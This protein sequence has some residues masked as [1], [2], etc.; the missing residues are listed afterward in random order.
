MTR[1]F[2][3][4]SGQ[5]PKGI[6]LNALRNMAHNESPATAAAIAYFT[7]FSIFPLLLLI[8]AIC[9]QYF[10]LF[11]V[12]SVAIRAVLQFF[13]G[14]RTF[15]Q[16]NIASVKPSPEIVISSAL[17]FLW[18][19][20]WL[21]A[22]LETALNK[23]WQVLTRR[24]FIRSRLLALLMLFVGGFFLGTSVILT[25]MIALIEHKIDH[26]GL[27]RSAALWRISFGVV[28]FLLTFLVFTLAYKLLP[29]T[30]VGLSEALTAGTVASILWQIASLLF[31]FL[32][33]HFDYDAIYGSVG[34]VVALL[35]WVYLSSYIFL[36]GAHLSAQMHRTCPEG[37]AEVL[38]SLPLP[39]RAK[40]P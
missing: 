3:T 10:N 31:T 39:E 23:A 12:R 20:F 21:V 15:I 37:R 38:A 33:R 28:A 29:N 5:G 16:N 27:V 35:S 1:L 25:T 13:P 22:L 17:I 26:Y 2:Q 19:L 32:V 24:H 36:F 34:A 7:L 8:I 40:A 18:T 14:L 30:H 6:L 9:D 4:R 11:D